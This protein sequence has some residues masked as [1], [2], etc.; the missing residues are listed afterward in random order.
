[1]PQWKQYSGIWT[2]TQQAQAIAAGTWTGILQPEL[3]AWGE[4]SQGQAG[5]GDVIDISS[6]VQV[7]SLLDWSNVA[8]GEEF[9]GAIKTDGTLWTWGDNSYGRLGNNTASVSTSSPVQIGS[10]TNWSS[11]SLGRDHGL[12]I[13]TNGTLWSW[14]RAASY[15]EP[16]LNNRINQS[17]PVQ[18]GSLTTWAKIAASRTTS[19]AIKTDGTLWTWGY[20]YAGKLGHNNLIDRSSPTQVGA[21]TNWLEVS[22]SE[23]LTLAT[24]TDGT[25]WSWGSNSSGA[26]GGGSTLPAYRSSPVQVGALTDW[27]IPKAGSNAAVVL[28]TDGTMWS[29]ELVAYLESLPVSTTRLL[30][31]LAL[32]PIGIKQL[33]ALPTPER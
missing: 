10:L 4:N 13:K 8:A 28:K 23:Y 16:G 30:Y 5:I 29:W 3:Y 26:L 14:G 27:S 18:V 22:A 12:A 15:G 32:T 21:L 1:M 31:K 11:L 33:R 24:K 19:A 20:N 6:P 9:G 2:P 17:S 7:G 25:V